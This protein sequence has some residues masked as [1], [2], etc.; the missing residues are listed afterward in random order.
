MP[1]FKLAADARKNE[2]QND[3]RGTVVVKIFLSEKG[4][5]QVKGNI[6]RSL[7]FKEA[8]VSEV[9]EAI[10]KYLVANQADDSEPQDCA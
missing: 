4:H 2:N 7:R 9:K 3:D 10:L 1:G 5:R 8:K 6:S